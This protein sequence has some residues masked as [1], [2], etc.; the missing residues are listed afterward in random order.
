MVEVLVIEAKEIA[1]IQALLNE[2]WRALRVG[3]RHGELS[4]ARVYSLLA[5]R[6]R[7]KALLMSE[8]LVRP[9]KDVVQR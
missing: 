3:D 5:Q 9:M 2:H 6:A 4:P 8:A 7:L 1:Q